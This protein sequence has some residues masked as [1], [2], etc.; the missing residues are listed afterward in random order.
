MSQGGV[1]AWGPSPWVNH[2]NLN[3]L[4]FLKYYFLKPHDSQ[5]TEPVIAIILYANEIH[6]RVLLGNCSRTMTT[7]II[8]TVISA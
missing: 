2:C 1:R 6:F 8:T 4:K 5:L 7:T 3:Y